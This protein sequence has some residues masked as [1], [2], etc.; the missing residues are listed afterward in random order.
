MT[1][2]KVYISGLISGLSKEQSER[3]FS[4]VQ[5][6]LELAGCEAVNPMDNGLSIEAAWEEHMLEDIKN[7]MACDSVYMLANWQQSRGARIEYTIAVEMGKKIYL[8]TI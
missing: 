3:N 6:L 1:K 7:L 4:G 2:E 8:Q 5:A